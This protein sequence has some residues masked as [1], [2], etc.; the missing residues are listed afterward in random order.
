[1]FFNF[2]TS[3]YFLG[4]ALVRNHTIRT[5]PMYVAEP[6]KLKSGLDDCYKHNIEYQ[7]PSGLVDLKASVT[8]SLLPSACACTPNAK[9]LVVVHG[10]RLVMT[11]IFLRSWLVLTARVWP[12]ELAINGTHWTDCHAESRARPRVSDELARFPRHRTT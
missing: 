3:S 2:R 9:V 12:R 5:H 10:Y 4:C 11:S 7:R 1:M 8:P 6:I